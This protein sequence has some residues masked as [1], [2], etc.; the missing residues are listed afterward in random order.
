MGSQLKQRVHVL[1]RPSH[2][3]LFHK[4]LTDD[5][6]HRRFDEAF[7]MVS[8]AVVVICDRELVGVEITYTLR[9]WP[10]VSSGVGSGQRAST[11]HVKDSS[12]WRARIG[13]RST[14]ATLRALNE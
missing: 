12:V 10:R 4:A 2:L 5:L 1:P 13:C 11:S 6:I 3:M 9:A 14:D 7:E 8:I